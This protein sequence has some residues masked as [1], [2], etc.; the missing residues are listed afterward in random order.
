MEP[1]FP[2]YNIC[3]CQYFWCE[4]TDFLSK[5]SSLLRRNLLWVLLCS[6]TSSACAS[7]LLILISIINIWHKN[8][9]WLSQRQR[10]AGLVPMRVC[11]NSWGEGASL[12]LIGHPSS[13]L[14]QQ[15]C[16]MRY[17]FYKI[18]QPFNP[19]ISIRFVKAEF[20]SF[21]HSRLT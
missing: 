9:H 14:S 5:N 8:H 10:N 11:L 20:K 18:D 16:L 7:S 4:N 2:N 12:A 6:P 1:L 17:M 13:D 15:I 21:D 3:W 19:S